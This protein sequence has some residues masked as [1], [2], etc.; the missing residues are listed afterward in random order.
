MDEPRPPLQLS[1]AVESE[2]EAM[3]FSGRTVSA[4]THLRTS[5]GIG[6]K[7]AVEWVNARVHD[8]FANKI[9]GGLG[10]PQGRRAP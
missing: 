10:T 1:A 4:I 5:L 6:P 8:R 2:L 3:I 9:A 7:E